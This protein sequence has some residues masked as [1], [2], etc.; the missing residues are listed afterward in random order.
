[1]IGRFKDRVGC[2]PF[3]LAVMGIF[4]PLAPS[5]NAVDP[6]I[7]DFI[8][9]P[10]TAKPQT[11]WHWCNG[12][13]SYEGI[14][15]DLEELKEKGVAGVQI[16]NVAPG[17]PPGPILFMSQEWH[18]LFKHAVKEASRLGLEVCVHNCAGWSSS[19]GPWI[20]PEHAMQKVTWSEVQVKGPKK[21]DAVL[22][23]PPTVGGFYRDI[24][25]LAYPT[26]ARDWRIEGWEGKACFR[27]MDTPSR[28]TRPTPSDAII[29]KDRII[30]LTPKL[31]SDGRLA[32]DVPEGNW[33]IVRFGYTL[34]GAKN[35]PAPD[36]GRGWE[37]DKLSREALD[38]HWKH[39]IAPLLEDAGPLAGKTFKNV[40]IDSY[41][42]G[43]QNWT[44]KMREEFQKRCGY[45]ILPFLP[46]ITG[47]VVDS[48]DISERFLWDFRRTIA[49]LFAENY[50]GYFGE[51]CRKHG[52]LLWVEPYG[53]GPFDDITAGSKAD[54]PMSEFWL[55]HGIGLEKDW[56]AKLASSI[57]HIYGKQVVG[58]ESFTAGPPYSGWR[59]YP[60]YI[61][62]LGDLIFCSGVNRYVFHTYAHQP[63]IDYKPG[64]TMGPWGMQFNRNTTWWDY[65][66]AWLT[67]VAR[68]Q[69]LLQQGLF[70]GDV[71]FYV[72]ENSPV[73]IRAS[74]PLPPGYDF[75]ACDTETLLNRLSVKGNKLVLPNGMSYEVLV[76]PNDR[77]MTPKVLRKIGE[78]VKAGAFVIGPKPLRSPSLV[79]Y[80]KG[81][82]EVRKLADDIWGDCDG[83]RVTEHKYGE[84]M[85]FWGKSVEEVLKIKGIKPDFEF[86][87]TLPGT[88][89]N[90]IHRRADN[91]DIYFLA[92]MKERFE[93]VDCTFRVKG[94]LPELFFPDTGKVEK[95]TMFKFVEDRTRLTLSF[96]PYGSLF[97]VFRSTGDGES[98]ARILH[99]GKDALIP[100]P[101]VAGKLEIVKAIYGVLEDPGK[102]VDVT[103]HLRKMVRNNTLSVV[104]SNAIAGDPAPLIVKKMRVDYKWDDKQNTVIVNENELLEIPKGLVG[105]EPGARLRWDPKGKLELLAFEPGDYEVQTTA[106]KTVK[107]E[108]PSVPKPIEIG[109]PWEVHFPPKWGAPEK[110]VF[111]K[112]ISW[113]E[114]HE[115]G[116]RYFSGTARYVKEVEIPKDL[117]GNDKE[118]YL[119][120]GDVEVIARVKL[121]G[122]DLGI[123]WKKPYRVDITDAIKAGKNTLEIEVANL[124]ANRLIGDEKLPPDREWNPNGSLREI[125]QWVR[126]GKP[127]PTGRYTFATWRHHTKDSPLLPSGLLGPVKILGGVKKTIIQG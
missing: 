125:P 105:K 127:S 15:K 66:S 73:P 5:A 107:V 38:E 23:Q 86:E 31:S 1:M 53:N 2:S 80:P 69:Y 121:N 36:S 101:Q 115:E 89:I 74:Q 113:S 22:S 98:I 77:E 119:D 56:N 83:Q 75:D 10:Q 97:V 52:L 118:V 57:A 123:L 51:L 109:G 71:L 114:H 79:D 122:K 43:S 54:V 116:I 41:E 99:N 108:V 40:L 12:N 21:F 100:A 42:M 82:E 11:W 20:K 17:N 91:L 46:V 90:Y 92:N 126:E 47:R 4:F 88:A 50:Y 37:V 27:R 110:A 29:P 45:D 32:W 76:L 33:T 60:Y 48:L 8:N 55:G 25:V 49:D 24:A 63:W 112:L 28:D 16:F 35:A 124:W 62:P 103:E 64:M 106:G 3:A 96:E 9:P 68:C 81:D 72:G 93:T 39:A 19:G 120:L 26:P 111:E 18:E 30:D 34:T 44:P 6:L 65:A 58:A 78:L 14:T 87:G 13:V 117:I 7:A 61:K 94:K 59:D 67:Y 84:G 70:V 85:V 102:Q 95:A 104:A